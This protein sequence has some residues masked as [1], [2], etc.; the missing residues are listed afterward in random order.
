[1]AVETTNVLGAQSSDGG[2][3]EPPP[4]YRPKP[5]YHGLVAQRDVMVPMRDGVRLCVDIFRPETQERLPVLLA[6]SPYNKEL[7]SPVYAAVVPPQ[8]PWSAWWS[9]AAEAG[10]TE[11]LVA[12]GYVHVIGTTRGS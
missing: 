7:V 9:G 10:D 2:A 8:P 11:F 12:R 4:D 6:I 1:M 3:S 5:F